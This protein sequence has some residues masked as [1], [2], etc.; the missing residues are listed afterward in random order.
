MSITATDLQQFVQA[1]DEKLEV[2]ERNLETAIALIDRFVGTRAALVPEAV[3]DSA[4]LQLGQELYYRDQ[5][6]SSSG[7]QYAVGGEFVTAVP[8]TDPMHFIVPMLRPFV[9]WY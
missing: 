2:L 1:K 5:R 8:R 7:G 9:G 6:N 4:V 3:Y